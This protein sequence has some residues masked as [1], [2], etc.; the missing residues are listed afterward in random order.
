MKGLK[1]ILIIEDDTAIAQIE[2]DYLELAGFKV[3]VE[4]TG[5]RGLQRALDEAFD[6]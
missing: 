4:K 6:L 1:R 2:K 5:I 3:T